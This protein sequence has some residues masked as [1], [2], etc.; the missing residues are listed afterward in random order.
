M[1]VG[2]GA[3]RVGT[4]ESSDSNRVG[5]RRVGAID[6]LRLVIGFDRDRLGVHSESTGVRPRE[7]V[8]VAS[9][10]HRDRASSCAGDGDGA[11][12]VH[13]ADPGST[14]VRER[15]ETVDVVSCDRRRGIGRKSAVT[16]GLRSGV[17]NR[18]HLWG[19]DSNCQGL[20]CGGLRSSTAVSNRRT[21]GKQS[22]C[23]RSPRDGATRAHRQRRG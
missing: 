23:A 7:E 20:R 8:T 16:V 2:Q 17:G 9:V 18:D 14:R 12:G 13:I 19:L 1:G 4:N 10:V 6:F 15:S 21:E 5:E 3:D 22:R 11:D